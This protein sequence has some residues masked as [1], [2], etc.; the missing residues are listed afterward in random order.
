MLFEGESTQRNLD[1]KK[2]SNGT[3]KVSF[4]AK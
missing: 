2:T 3:Q 1:Y 4:T